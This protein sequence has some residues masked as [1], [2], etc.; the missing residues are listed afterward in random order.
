VGDRRKG[1]RLPE[2]Q[3]SARLL[4][5]NYKPFESATPA[6]QYGALVPAGGNAAVYI[7]AGPGN[8]GGDNQVYPPLPPT[9]LLTNLFNATTK[10][11]D[12]TNLGVYRPHFFERDIGLSSGVAVQCSP[13]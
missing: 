5:F 4:P 7:L 6:T 9:D 2:Q 10:P 8:P 12:H 3:R 13:D 1:F 11:A